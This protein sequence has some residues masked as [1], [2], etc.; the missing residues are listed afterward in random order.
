MLGILAQ[1]LLE[2]MTISLTGGLVGIPVGVAT[3]WAI[4]SFAGWP[5]PV[6]HE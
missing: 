6:R 5:A 3:S 1:F 2:A 4:A